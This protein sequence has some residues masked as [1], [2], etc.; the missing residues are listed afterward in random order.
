MP[1]RDSSK[2]KTRQT[3]DLDPADFALLVKL[4]EQL[5]CTKAEVFRRG[6]RLLQAQDVKALPPELTMQG[7]ADTIRAKQLAIEAFR[8]CGTVAVAASRANVTVRTIQHWSQTDEVFREL[9]N[10]AQALAIGLVKAKMF[11]DAI[12]GNTSAQF[13]IL[14]AHDPH[15]GQIRTAMLQKVIEPLL[16]AVVENA[17][18]YLSDDQ[19]ERFASECGRSGERVALKAVGGR[20]R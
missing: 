15:F 6:F 13:G 1:T 10:E 20:S 8:V 5:Q 18:R 11:E 19:L 7:D 17:R 12:G 16:D 2:R 4:A 9:A 3:V 14:N